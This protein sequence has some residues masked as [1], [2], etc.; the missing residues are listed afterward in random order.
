[1]KKKSRI[2]RVRASWV[3]TVAFGGVGLVGGCTAPVP[4]P[5]PTA[6]PRQGEA[7]L[8]LENDVCGYDRCGGLDGHFTTDGRC[9]DGRWVISHATCN[10][11]PP[12]AEDC[13]ASAP[14]DGSGC[15]TPGLWCGYDACDDAFTNHANCDGTTWK[16]SLWTC[17]PPSPPP[18]GG[19]APLDGGAVPPRDGAE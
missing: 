15:Q 12:P 4:Q 13:P 9:V 3:T 2:P 8:P 7:C 1:M 11:P 17:N 14:V 5:C 19:A 6:A 16:V 18:D 10:P